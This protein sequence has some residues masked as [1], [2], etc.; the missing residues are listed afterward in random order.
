MGIPRQPGWA[1][2]WSVYAFVHCRCAPLLWLFLEGCGQRPPLLRQK[3]ARLRMACVQCA[4][5][6][7]QTSTEE[8]RAEDEQLWNADRWAQAAVK[9]TSLW[10]TL[11]SQVILRAWWEGQKFS[12]HFFKKKKEK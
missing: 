6:S 12:I 5:L 2:H 3:A 11:L 8:Q 10:H 1:L 9:V 7:T 4:V